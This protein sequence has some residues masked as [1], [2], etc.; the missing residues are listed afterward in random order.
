VPSEVYHDETAMWDAGVTRDDVAAFLRDYRYGDN[1]G[2][3]VD[4][5]VVDRDRLDRRP[6]RFDLG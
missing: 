3:Y 2:A 6:L 1:I 5:A 4:H